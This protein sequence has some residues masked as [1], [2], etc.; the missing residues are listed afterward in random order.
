MNYLRHALAL[1]FPAGCVYC[2]APL[3]RARVPHFCDPCWSEFAPVRGAV[4]PTCGRP[5]GSPEALIAS[6]GHECRACRQFPP[7]FDQALSAGVFEGQLR[8]AIHCYKYRPALSLGRPLAEWMA[9]Q[10]R[11]VDTLDVVMPVPLHRKR[12]KQRGFN[13]ALLLA[14]VIA[15]RSG[16]PLVYDS[17]LRIRDTRPQV[18]LSGA[19]RTKNVRGAFSVALPATVQDKRI[20]LVDDVLTTGATMNECARELKQAGASSVTAL[21]LARADA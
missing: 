2:H 11:V 10:I 5:L 12:L 19:D 3:N 8:E 6:P 4:C 17:L 1:L 9:N 16:L 13:Q 20:L 18:D 14:Q 21:T 15:E 7:H